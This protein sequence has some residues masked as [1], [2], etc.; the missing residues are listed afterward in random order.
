MLK[1]RD[2]ESLAHLS[3][4]TRIRLAI[5]ELG[6]TFI[7]LGQILSTRPDQVGMPLADEL[8]KLQTDVPA[9][10]AESIRATIETELGAP[11]EALFVDFD[12]TPLASASIGQVHRARQRRRRRSRRQGPARRHPAPHGGRSRHSGRPGPAGRDAARARALPPAGDGR[13]ISPRGAPRARLRPRGPQHRPVRP[14]LPPQ[15][16]RPHPPL[17][18]RALDA[19]RA[20]DGMARRLAILRSPPRPRKTFRRETRSTWPTSPA[21]APRCTSK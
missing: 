4:E 1:N 19:A 13:R 15:P 9:D 7:K 17:L 8:Q 3:R 12:P 6:P 2:G 16:T 5:E 14:Q 10:D 21:T 20:D 18:P 11:L